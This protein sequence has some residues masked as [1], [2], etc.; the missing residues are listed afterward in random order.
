MT[1]FGRYY[2]NLFLGEERVV[3]C[4]YTFLES[5]KLAFRFQLNIWPAD[6]GANLREMA[7]DSGIAE[8][9]LPRDRAL[10]RYPLNLLKK[11]VVQSSHMANT[12]VFVKLSG[13]EDVYSIPYRDQT[14]WYRESLSEFY[15]SLYQEKDF[16]TS[17]LGRILRK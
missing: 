3:A 8:S 7:C 13:E 2:W 5:F 14:D 11:I 6:P 15:P 1:N 10:R 16:P 9:D 4:P 12:I 17:K